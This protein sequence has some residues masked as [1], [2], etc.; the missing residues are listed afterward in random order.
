ME[1]R[2]RKIAAGVFIPCGAEQVWQ[3]LTDYDRLA[4]FIPN[5]AR[6]RRIDHPEGKIQV[7][8]VGSECL[9]KMK[10]CARVV[11]EMV[12]QFPH[13]IE[14]KMVEGDFKAF[15]GNWSLQPIEFKEKSG[16]LRSGTRLDYTAVIW[17]GRLMPVGMIERRLSQN[18]RINLAAIHHR[19]IRL[20]L[21]E[22]V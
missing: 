12:E 2:Q 8:Q 21:G 11:L 1:G 14:F 16:D 19:T 22:E 4:D 3:V 18:L 9:L 6:S 7:E 20:Y 13:Q 10:F 15:S 17:P 5:L